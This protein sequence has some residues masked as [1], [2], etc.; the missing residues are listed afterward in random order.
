MP[1]PPYQPRQPVPPPQPEHDRIPPLMH[2][3][4][5][6]QWAQWKQHPIT[7]LL[8]ERYL[9]D[10]RAGLE[11][12]VLDGWLTGNVPVQQMDIYKGHLLGAHLIET[13]TFDRLQEFYGI[14]PEARKDGIGVP[15]TP[16]GYI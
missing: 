13:L 6:Q 3:L 7:H 12:Q 2:E 11:R 9:P 8:F 10:F 14:I 5:A 1:L 16:R 4:S 15:P